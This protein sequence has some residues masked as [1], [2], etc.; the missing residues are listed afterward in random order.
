[1]RT[2]THMVERRDRDVYE[3]RPHPLSKAAIWLGRS[4][5]SLHASPSRLSPSLVRMPPHCDPWHNGDWRPPPF[6][7]GATL[8]ATH[9]I[10]RDAPYVDRP[11]RL[12]SSS[13]AS[14]SGVPV[15]PRRCGTAVLWTVGPPTQTA[16]RPVR[17]R[18]R[19][20]VAE[21]NGSHSG[22]ASFGHGAVSYT[23][24]TLPTN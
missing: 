21:G 8:P 23:H 19:H 5:G 11:F 10:P 9:P 3:K 24:L 2:D 4:C 14:I 17:P 1:M 15:G 22:F 18:V 20:T 16:S 12:A 7:P 13:R 6:D